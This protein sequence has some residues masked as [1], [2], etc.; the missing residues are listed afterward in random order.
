MSLVPRLRKSAMVAERK[1]WRRLRNRQITGY[2][3]R[4]RHELGPYILVFYRPELR[5]A[6]EL[7][8]GGYG[9]ISPKTS[10]RERTTF[11]EKQGIEVLRF[12]NRQIYKEFDTFCE[13]IWFAGDQRAKHP[14]PESS[15]RSTRSRSQGGGK[16]LRR[17]QSVHLPG[18]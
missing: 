10:D 3:F 14:A 5:I 17:F 12:W 1:V 9:Y 4:R 18:M 16:E 15:Q 7:D 13:A 11:L 6:I 2:K 8:G